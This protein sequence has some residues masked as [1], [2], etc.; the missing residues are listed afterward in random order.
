MSDTFNEMMAAALAESVNSNGSEAPPLPEAEIETLRE[1]CGNYTNPCP[2][3]I[4]DIIT[5]RQGY[6]ITNAGRPQIVVEIADPPHR[7]FETILPDAHSS[8][9]WGSRLDIRV[10]HYGNGTLIMHWVE[11]WQFEPYTEDA[12]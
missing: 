8:Q 1:V 2:F 4:G 3:R 9:A 6:N 10:A 11:S 7:N 5:P 12:A